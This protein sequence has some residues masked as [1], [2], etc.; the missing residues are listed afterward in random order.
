MAFSRYFMLNPL[1]LFNCKSS[2]FARQEGLRQLHHALGY[3]L[4][5]SP[6]LTTYI[7]IHIIHVIKIYESWLKCMLRMPHVV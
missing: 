3:L 2:A 6:L 1:S 4:G 7:S 5:K